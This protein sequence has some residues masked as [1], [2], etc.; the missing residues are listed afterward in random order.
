MDTSTATVAALPNGSTPV[1]AVAASATLTGQS[2]L[3]AERVSILPSGAYQR[4]GALMVAVLFGGPFTLSPDKQHIIGV[5]NKSN[6]SLQNHS[7]LDGITEDE[8]AE[9]DSVSSFKPMIVPIVPS[10]PA[11]MSDI[12][13]ELHNNLQLNTEFLTRD[14]PH[15]MN[16]PNTDS[17]S[18]K[19]LTISAAF[20]EIV[21]PLIPTELLN[22]PLFGSFPATNNHASMPMKQTVLPNPTN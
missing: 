20:I 17:G 3:R 22:K 7:D 10:L 6:L 4:V 21:K 9:L 2:K 11:S 8:L 18:T 12:I 13:Q 16:F 15:T 14:K 19:K 1:F 5:S